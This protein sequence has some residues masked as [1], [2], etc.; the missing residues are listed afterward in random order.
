MNRFSRISVIGMGYIGLPT[1]A[2]FA[3]NGVEVLGIDVNPA[4]VDSINRGEPH[5]VEPELDVL[6]RKVVQGG[7]LRASL[8]P[9]PADA[10][11]LAVPTPFQD[12]HEPDVSYIQAAA[13]AIAPVLAK[14]NLVILESTSP[15][16]T[17][18][19][20]SRWLGEARQDLSFPHQTGELSDIRIAHCPERVLPGRILREVVENDRIIGGLT[21]KCAQAAT[22]LYRVFVKGQIHLTNARTAEMAKL[23]ENAFRDVNIAFANELSVICDRL[24]INVWELIRLANQHPRVNI[25]RPGPGVGGHCIAV[26]P[27]FIVAAD[28][29][30]SRLIRT[31][32]E[33]NDAKPHWVVEKVK[34]Q[35]A[36]LKAPVVACLGLSYKADVDDL[37]ESPAVEIVEHLAHEKVAELLVVEP[38]VNALPKR[39]ADLGL[40]L[41]DFD[42]A[43]ERANILLLL[44][45]HASFLQVDHDVVKDKIVVDTRGAW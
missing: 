3:D 4:A 33:V 45:D 7:K 43:T 13:R 27:W 36:K 34:A 10:F 5:I 24:K 20:L 17:T 39:L 16:G 1:S 40:K 11:I 23:T 15:I 28:P 32:R 8:T 21:R 30:R 12:N 6:L 26:D 14:G 9:E 18:E 31:A 35:A 2:V 38:H 22:A 41:W 44:V 37:R 42:Q 25:L 29:A 19:S